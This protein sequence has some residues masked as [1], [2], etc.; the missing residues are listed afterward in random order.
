MQIIQNSRMMASTSEVL[1]LQLV[2]DVFQ[3]KKTDNEVNSICTEI[4]PLKFYYKGR[5]NKRWW[6]YSFEWY[7]DEGGGACSLRDDSDAGLP[8]DKENDSDNE[9][10]IHLLE[11]NSFQENPLDMRQAM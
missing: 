4:S 10:E 9:T 8:V 2:P 7:R 6:D 3:L 5:T 11:R 1:S